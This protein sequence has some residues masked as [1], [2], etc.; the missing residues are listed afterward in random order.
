MFQRILHVGRIRSAV[1]PDTERKPQPLIQQCLTK[2]CKESVA[3][4]IQ[5]VLIIT[6]PG[7]SIVKYT[8][9]GT[10]LI[11]VVLNAGACIQ[12]SVAPQFLLPFITQFVFGLSR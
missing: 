12:R 2:L 11:M 8:T 10:V 9:V 1:G 5:V 4:K 7:L 6:R 3:E